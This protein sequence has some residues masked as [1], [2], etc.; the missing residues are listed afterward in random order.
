MES[1][2][3]FSIDGESNDYTNTLNENVNINHTPIQSRTSN[4]Q[5]VKNVIK[6]HFFI[7]NCCFCPQLHVID[8]CTSCEVD[9][10]SHIGL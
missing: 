2:D 1:F 4:I 3:N 7:W 5:K 10:Q 9:V 8:C 6:K